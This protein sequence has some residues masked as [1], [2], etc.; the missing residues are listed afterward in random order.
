MTDQPPPGAFEE[1][2]DHEEMMQTL[3]MIRQDTSQI[4]T[5]AGVV[6]LATLVM[7][8]ALVLWL[9]GAVTIKFEPVTPGF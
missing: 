4:R 7:A 8:V 3:R 1:R 2:T 9:A 6:A 5:Y